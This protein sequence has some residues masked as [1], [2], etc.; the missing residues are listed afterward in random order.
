MVD[1]NLHGGVFMATVNMSKAAEL[2]GVSRQ[3]IYN[4]V[5]KGILSKN[6]DG[7]ID[8]SELLRVF[9]NLRFDS[10]DKPSKDV[11]DRHKFTDSTCNSDVNLQLAL[12]TQENV[13]LKDKIERLEADKNRLEEEKQRLWTFSEAMQRALPEGRKEQPKKVVRDEL[14][15]FK[16]QE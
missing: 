4:H 9:Q 8:T 1:I 16:K 6:S 11:S 5:K 14:G 12:L 15:R 3:T 7:T 13:F 10:Q 2:A